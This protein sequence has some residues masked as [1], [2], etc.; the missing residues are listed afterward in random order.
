LVESGCLALPEVTN[1]QVTEDFL[2]GK[3]AMIVMEPWVAWMAEKK[4]GP[5][6]TE[7]IG[8][9]LPPTLGAN[10]E[11]ATFLGGSLLVVM[12]PTKGRQPEAVQAASEFMRFLASGD[13]ERHAAT[14]QFLPGSPKAW[15]SFRFRKIFQVGI[16]HGKSPPRFPEWPEV[17]E[18]LAVRD[19]LYWFWKRLAVLPRA[20]DKVD[21]AY[22]QQQRAMVLETLHSA[23][24]MMNKGLSPGVVGRIVKIVA[25]VL[26]CLSPI[27]VAVFWRTRWLAR[28]ERELLKRITELADRLEQVQQESERINR[29]MHPFT[30]PEELSSPHG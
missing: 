1:L 17:V 7:H 22:R 26:L 10:E 15:E 21:K 5:A 4:W 28:R 24:R 13:V 6:W 9:T 2:N 27:A 3:Y 20:E 25:I 16:D 8:A 11:P 19:S 23:A 18:N 29:L 30:L 14:V 12:D